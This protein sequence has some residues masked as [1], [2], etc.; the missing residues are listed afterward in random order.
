MEEGSKE[1]KSKALI[2]FVDSLL[3]RVPESKAYVPVR[4][5]WVF[6]FVVD[7]L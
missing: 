4:N 1:M 6:A 7:G 5:D 3:V 2:Y